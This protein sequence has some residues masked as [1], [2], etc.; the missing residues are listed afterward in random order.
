[1][2]FSRPGLCL[3]RLSHLPWSEIIGPDWCPVSDVRLG[4]ISPV[5]L[6]WLGWAKIVGEWDLIRMHGICLYASK[7]MIFIDM[8]Y[9]PET[10]VPSKI[11]IWCMKDDKNHLVWKGTL[12]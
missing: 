11:S 3:S 12:F 5:M 8:W 4:K 10:R 9:C 2:F 1:V 6:G 7:N